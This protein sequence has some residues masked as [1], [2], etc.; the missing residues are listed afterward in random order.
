MISASCLKLLF[1]FPVYVVLSGSGIHV[2]WWEHNGGGINTIALPVEFLK[3][4]SNICTVDVISF[5]G[6]IQCSRDKKGFCKLTLALYR[7]PALNWVTC[8]IVYYQQV[9]LDFSGGWSVSFW[10]NKFYVCKPGVEIL[11]LFTQLVEGRGN[12]WTKQRVLWASIWMQLH[13]LELKFNCLNDH[14]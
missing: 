9:S 2:P 3:E 14:K 11:F 12:S 4:D 5:D 6:K 7:D 10:I 13:S 1:S 8:K